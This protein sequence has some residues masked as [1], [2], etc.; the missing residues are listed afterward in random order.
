MLGDEHYQF[1][2]NLMDESK[3]EMCSKKLKDQLIK[4]YADLRISERSVS[5]AR[6]ELGWV[7]QTT[8]YCQAIRDVHKSVRLEWAKKM[9]K[10]EESFNVIFK[11]EST[12]QVEYHRTKCYRR[13]VQPRILKSRPKH[14]AKIH[15]WGGISRKGATTVVLFKANMTATR[16]TKIMD[17][18][19]VPFIA[20]NLP[21]HHRFYQDNDPKHTS[22]WA[23]WFFEKHN[24]NWWMSP[25]ETPNLNPIENA[26]ESIKQAL[27][28]EYKPRTLP[29]LEQAI[30]HYWQ[31]KLTPAVCS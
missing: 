13:I 17:A 18:S 21:D 3:G 6:C 2:D 5:R 20:K 26:W 15:A 25:P 22:R 4:N 9:L 30:S 19:L 24:I 1:I 11:P 31:T 8:K 16:Y 7:F 14:P 12:F 23:Q 10:E 28:S 27:R 29:E